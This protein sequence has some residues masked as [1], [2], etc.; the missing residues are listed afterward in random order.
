MPVKLCKPCL[1]VVLVAAALVGPVLAQSLG[2]VA[3][4]EEER[5]KSVK[6]PARVYT[7][8]DLGGAAPPSSLAT[9]SASAEPA[10][11]ASAVQDDKDKKDR[12]YWAGRRKALQD[13]FDSD[14][15][16]ADALQS[17]I[18]ALNTDFA[19]RSD[20]AQRAVIERDRNKALD[21]L[22]RL[23]KAVLDGKK[24]LTDLDEEARKAGVP[25]GWL[26]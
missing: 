1:A 5:R 3:R 9:P 7:N 23:Q 21:D 19:A 20:P 15:S 16:F 14:Q 8:K 10:K 2:E 6:N 12:T 22:K 11:P 18:N 4:K 26:R 13:K 17:K 24:A 25:P